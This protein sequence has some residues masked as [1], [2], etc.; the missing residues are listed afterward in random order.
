MSTRQHRDEEKHPVWDISREMV[1]AA[2]KR[3]GDLP[4]PV[5][6]KERKYDENYLDR[7]HNP[8]VADGVS[9]TGRKR[10]R[11]SAEDRTGICVYLFRCDG[12]GSTVS[13]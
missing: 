10:R 4:D 13:V 2:L 11:S 3:A 7:K 9:S 12:S 6:K 5:N 8:G 1:A